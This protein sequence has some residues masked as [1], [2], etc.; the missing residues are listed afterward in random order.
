MMANT[1]YRTGIIHNSNIFSGFTDRAILVKRR[2]GVKKFIF[3]RAS[4]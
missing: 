4:H 1:K 2:Q 3:K